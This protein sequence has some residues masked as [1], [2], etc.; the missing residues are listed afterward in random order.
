MEMKHYKL[1]QEKIILEDKDV[2]SIF[3]TNGINLKLLTLN[4]PYRLTRS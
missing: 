4:D 3:K 1:Q 2:V